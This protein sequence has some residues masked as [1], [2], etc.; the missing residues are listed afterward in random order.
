MDTEP[1]TKQQL[2]RCAQLLTRPGW[3][4]EYHTG[5]RKCIAA[6]KRA[7]ARSRDEKTLPERRAR[8]TAQ[9]GA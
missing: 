9:E 4:G 2:Q 8:R 6:A 3:H 7:E 5:H 1:L